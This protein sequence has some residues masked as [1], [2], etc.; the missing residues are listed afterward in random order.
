MSRRILFVRHGE[1]D[2]NAERRMQGQRNI[3]LNATGEDQGRAVGTILATLLPGDAA[4]DV[5]CSPLMRCVRTFELASQTY[6]QATGS[7][8]RQPAFDDRLKEIT[9]GPMEG[10]T[11]A[12][13]PPEQAAARK[14]DHWSFKVEGAESYADGAARAAE[15]FGE[16][17]GDQSTLLIF[18]HGGICRGMRHHLLDMPGSEAAASAIPQGVVMEWI[19]ADGQWVETLHQL[20]RDTV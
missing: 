16:R 19:G 8:L 14:A 17:A 2:W 18:S 11:I 6:E 9:F 20:A 1:T 5:W 15:W 3:P 10:K 12:E 13:L 4:P 7:P